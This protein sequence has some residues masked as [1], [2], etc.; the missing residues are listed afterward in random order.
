MHMLFLS[1]A[2]FVIASAAVSWLGADGASAEPRC[3]S[4]ARAAA[5]ASTG[6]LL[7]LLALTKCSSNVAAGIVP[8]VLALLTC[9]ELWA[10]QPRPPVAEPPESSIQEDVQSLPQR[11]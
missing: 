5:R 2:T 11:S 10:V 6:L 4:N 8:T 1:A 9:I 3:S 7:G